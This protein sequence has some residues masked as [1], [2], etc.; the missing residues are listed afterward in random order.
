MN[1]TAQILTG[2]EKKRRPLRRHL[3]KSKLLNFSKEDMKE[4]NEVTKR[5]REVDVL[6]VLRNVQR[7]E[8]RLS[9]QERYI[10]KRFWNE[11][12]RGCEFDAAMLYSSSD[13]TRPL[14]FFIPTS[15]DGLVGRLEQKKGD[16]SPVK[17][18]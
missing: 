9:S 17:M 13:T 6:E 2:L 11:I 4:A 7:E 5:T 16:F 10:D 14:T 15:E 8:K 12:E 18:D 3:D 1:L